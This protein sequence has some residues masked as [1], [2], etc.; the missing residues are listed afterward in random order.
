MNEVA[1]NQVNTGGLF[2]GPNTRPHINTHTSA[3][4]MLDECVSGMHY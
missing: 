2:I 4:P 1:S 3:T